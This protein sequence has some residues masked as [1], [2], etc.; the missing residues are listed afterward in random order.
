[1]L[2]R[3]ITLFALALT[4]AHAA[5]RT[6]RSADGSKTFDG[7]FIKRE[8]TAVTISQSGGK[9]ITFDIARLHADDQKWINLY[10]PTDDSKKSGPVTNGV[11]DDL[12]FGD[13]RKQVEEKLKKS[14]IV[15]SST[16]K[17][18]KTSF[19]G[20]SISDTE[21][22]TKEKIGELNAFLN[23]TWDENDE[24][25]T[26]VFLQT[27][28]VSA[29]SYDD[30]LKICW[31]EF[32]ELLTSLHG[33]PVQQSAFPSRSQVPQDAII[34]SHIWKLHKGGTAMLGTACS[35]DKYIVVV[36]FSKKTVEEVQRSQTKP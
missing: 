15:E 2:P 19:F 18:S 20:I 16:G 33:E 35:G 36:R 14:P 1:M 23:F 10:H 5:P 8:G 13:T 22:R 12:N 6:W 21:Y 4:C 29:I 24:K 32:I 26:E 7:E 31:S 9:E 11:F 3:L 17:A 30:T 25:L 28:P 27:E 34:G